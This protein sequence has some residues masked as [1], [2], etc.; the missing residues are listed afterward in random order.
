MSDD[1]PAT[2][3]MSVLEEHWAQH[4]RPMLYSALGGK[5]SADAKAKLREGGKK[6]SD[7]VQ[8]DMAALVRS[9][10]LTGHGG[11]AVP[12][13]DAVEFSDEE[14]EAR[15]PVP[16]ARAAVSATGPSHYYADVWQAFSSPMKGRRRFLQVETDDVRL[17]DVDDDPIDTSWKE[18]SPEN[19]A[20]SGSNGEPPAPP[21]I[22]EAVRTWAYSNGLSP[23]QLRPQSF[24]R[25][26]A[27]SW[28]LA[29]SR[30]ERPMRASSLKLL[31]SFLQSLSPSELQSFQLSGAVL[32]SIIRRS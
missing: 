22:A 32:L 14:L 16:I 24:R 31:D 19:I 27:P 29:G 3:I 6:L 13:S 23:R 4:Q 1:G 21:A 7:F 30:S 15:I 8:R 20:S 28:P 9:L 10:S 26:V 5:L 2:E 12:R 18:V 25:E 17:H 11:G